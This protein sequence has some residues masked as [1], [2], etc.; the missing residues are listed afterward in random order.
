MLKRILLFAVLF[1]A[2][3]AGAHEKPEN[4]LQVRSEH[5]IVATNSSEKQARRVADQ[6]ERM[7]LVFHQQFPKLPIDP[8]A[9]IIVLALKDEKDFRALEPEAYL[10][11]GQV[12]LGGLFLHAPDKNYILMRL[13]AQGEHPYE[14]IYHEYT[15]LLLG[16]SMEWLPLWLNEGLAEFYQNTDIREKEV[17]LG[18]PSAENLQLLRQQT[19]MP[20][21]TLFKVDENSPYY[22]EEN[23]GSIFYAESWA[24]THYLQ[25]TDAKQRTHKL[26]DYADLLAQKTDPVEAA[27]RTFGD[28]Q[29]L[30]R[31][32]ESY[33][34]QAAFLVFK[35]PGA[36]EIDESKF[37]VQPLPMSQSE[38]IRAD[39]L[40]YNQRIPDAQALLDQ[41]LKDDPN[42]VLAHETMGYLAFRAGHLDD[43]KKWYGEAVQLDSHSYLAHYYFAAISMN[44]PG[45]S[46]DD[47]RVENSLRESIK[48]NPQ[49][50]PSFDRLAVFLAVRRRN[51]DEA[52]TV[53]LTAVSLEPDNVGY[54]INVANV[55][56]NMK[57]PDAAIQVLQAAAKLAKT[58]QEIAQV[59]NFL[60]SAQ[61]FDSAQQKVAEM[62]K[63]TA[64]EQQEMDSDD[65]TAT[66]LIH[67]PAFVPKGPHLFLVG[68]LKDV[69]CHTSEMD[70][71]VTSELK[72]LS[73]HADDYYQI[74]FTALNFTPSEDLNPCKDLE[75]RP[76]KVEYVESADPSAS[77]HLLAIELHK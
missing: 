61:A 71:T 65:D 69:R 55:L 29:Q 9:P 18:E 56:M 36:T 16:K 58:P 13:D 39:F 47:A 48:L 8:P 20:L 32:L 1:S 68:V 73:L 14:I 59:N 7:R 64:E 25:I 75:G 41:T 74:R 28:L 2:A 27:H 12:K 42:N 21:A 30:Q 67:R 60:M 19:L 37:Q 15:H 44:N 24:L 57:R 22:H 35:V 6:F 52:H 38:A 62:Q 23:K 49:F 34:R 45:S 26:T 3:A 50:A 66:D 10:A 40:A 33:V 31:A 70:L 51:L 54:R 72:N 11:K 63:E 17:L 43:A 76:A 53:G 5:F 46:A 77:P 4:W